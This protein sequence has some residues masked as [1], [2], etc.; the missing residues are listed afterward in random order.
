MLYLLPNLL[1]ESESHADVLPISVDRA[2]RTLDHLIAESEKEGRRFLKRFAFDPPK[3]F[4]DIHI[5]L[6]N[7]HTTPQER[8]EL[9]QQ[10]V[11]GQNAENWALISDCGMPCLADPG[12]DFILHARQRGVRIQAFAGPS[13]ILLALV[14][15]GLGGQRFSFRGYL[16][17]E[18]NVRIK[19]LEQMQMSSNKERAVYLFIETPYRNQKLFEQLLR[20]LDDK[21]WLCLAVELTLPTEWVKTEKIANWKKSASPPTLN[22]RPT[23]FAIRGF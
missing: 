1:G 15:S 10:V 21:T 6:L 2:V 23:V 4:R 5:H 7:E 13:S 19:E 8:E 3:T 18:E 16:H 12:E 17:R 9:L 11:R 14:L 20:H 22:D